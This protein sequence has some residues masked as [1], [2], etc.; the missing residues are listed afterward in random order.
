MPGRTIWTVVSVMVA[1]AAVTPACSS[2]STSPGPA[3]S[4][5]AVSSTPSTPQAHG[6]YEQCLADH[7]VPAPSGPSPR[8]GHAPYGPP[9]GPPPAA[10]PPLPPGATP[11]PPT[12]VDQGTWDNAVSACKSLAPSPPGGN[13]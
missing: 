13:P 7:G 8:N 12:G 2:N 6:A 10:T 5:T 4:S 9:P 3:P 11:P 1:V